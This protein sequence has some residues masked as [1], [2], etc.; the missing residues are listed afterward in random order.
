MTDQPEQ[1]TREDLRSMT[2]QQISDARRAGSLRALLMARSDEGEPFTGPDGAPGAGREFPSVGAWLRSMTP[3]QVV[4]AR[5]AG[6]IPGLERD[7]G[8]D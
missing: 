8:S 4:A 2:P 7:R 5:R 3:H 1:L 6:L